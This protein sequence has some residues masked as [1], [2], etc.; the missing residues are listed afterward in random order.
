M[1]L[2]D[3]GPLAEPISEHNGQAV[4]VRPLTDHPGWLAK[5]YRSDLHPEDARRIDLLISAPDK[6]PQA[7]RAALYAETCWPAA[8]IHGPDNPAVGC[9]IPMAPEQY[10]AELRRGKFSERRFVEIDWLAK[11][12]ESIRGVGLPGPGL[13]GRLAACRRLTQLAAILEALELVYS[14]WSFSNAFWSPERRSVY[15]IDVD[16]CQPKKMPDLHQP[17]WADP[18]TPPGTDAD[19][20]TDRYRLGLLVAKCLTGHRDA[21]AF[22][23]VAESL[24]QAQPAVCE[25]LL[26][27]LLATDRERRPAAAQLNQAL[28]N[29]PYLR[30][31]PRPTRSPLPE[32]P[33][34]LAA[35]PVLP[36]R[37]VPSEVPVSPQPADT[38]TT[39]ATQKPAA[40]SHAAWIFVIVLA[41]ILLVIIVA[42][43]H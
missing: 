39:G 8:R 21:R 16:G 14:D 28:N 43:N 37:S 12:D 36:V 27:M 38:G 30:A 19:Q 32:L 22:H 1:A 9:V 34:V 41:A 25:V 11:S 40:A 13:E 29:G 26:D 20:Y 35:P 31:A 4:A 3:L 24:R 23:T 6:L 42:A 18:L 33:P 7:D 15:L 5:L 10:R 17:N 2:G